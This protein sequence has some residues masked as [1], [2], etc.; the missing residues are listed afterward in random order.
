MN[1]YILSTLLLL[2]V[3]GGFAQ[4]EKFSEEELKI[5]ELIEGTLT[6]PSNEEAQSIVILIQASGP[7]DRNGNQSMAKNDGMKKI[8]RELSL[9]GVASYR[10]DK[11]IFKMQELKMNLEDL[12]F[13]DLIIDVQN[14]LTYFKEKDEFENLIVA[15]HSQ[16]SLIGIIAAKE[17][18]DAFISLAG[19][20][21]AIDQIIVEQFSKMAPELGEST[22]K[23]FA[24][25]KENGSTKN[26]N[27]MLASIFA[28][29]VQ[30]F[31]KSW[32]AYQPSEEIKK[33][34]IPILIL[35]G[36][37]DI[38]TESKEA[39]ML[40]NAT[41]NSKLVLLENMNHIFRKVDS[42]DRLV[43]TKSY[44]EPGRP[45]HPDLIPVITEFIKELE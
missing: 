35:N 30:P 5:N 13:S 23:K 29:Y 17:H 26:D 2:A 36:T 1:K 3:F 18:A 8:A 34:D 7:T 28:P 37:F 33:L 12:R 38:Q 43:N 45:L 10:F 41:E 22:R 20:G 32:V 39:E 31:I 6:R 25:L 15:G 40:H 4:E 19:A 27:P 11:R 44:N 24:E 9:N 16:G 21:Q 42:K 14:I